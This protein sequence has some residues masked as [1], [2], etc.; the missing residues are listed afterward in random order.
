MVPRTPRFLWLSTYFAAGV[1]ALVVT[2]PSGSRLIGSRSAFSQQCRYPGYGFRSTWHPSKSFGTCSMVLQDAGPPDF[3][4]VEDDDND[5]GDN[6]G[7]EVEND[8]QPKPIIESGGIPRSTVQKLRV[9]NMPSRPKRSPK[10]EGT[11]WLEKNAA[12]SG[13]EYESPIPADDSTKGRPNRTFRQDFQGTRVFVQGIPLDA[14]WQDLKDHFAIAGA[15]VFA[16][17]S[18][19]SATGKS[20]GCGI[21]QFETSEMA[22]HAIAEMRNH[23]MF[24]ST[25]FVRED[26]QEQRGAGDRELRSRMPVNRRDSNNKPPNTWECADDD[27]SSV[28]SEDE[29]DSVVALVKARDAARRRRNYEASDEMRHELKSRYGVHVDDRL[30]QWWVSFDGSHVPQNVKAV[31]GD[32]RWGDKKVWQQILTTPENDACVNPDLVNGLL[33]QRDIARR[34]KDFSTADALLDE[35]RNSPDGELYLR[36]HDES[37]TW[38]IWT[39]KPPAKSVDYHPKPRLSA[40]EQCIAL[41][42]E[43]A[44]HKEEEIKLLLQK[45]PGREYPILKKLRKS[46]EEV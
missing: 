1:H 8:I 9:K 14:K 32:G 2:L 27:N 28:L 19:D 42:R 6:S 18:V 36:I 45:F 4:I 46:L 25:L 29:R 34:E 22:L 5:K 11:S 17:V 40:A 21:V 37:R 13:E 41:I 39:D 43:K 44:P 15:V 30:K 20:K 10:L 24:G 12:F 3:T 35:A 23:P 16:S 38:R 7:S 33:M 31:K 26:V